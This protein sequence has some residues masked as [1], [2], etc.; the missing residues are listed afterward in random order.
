SAR[1]SRGHSS[2]RPWPAAALHRRSDPTEATPPLVLAVASPTAQDRAELAALHRELIAAG[3]RGVAVIVATSDSPPVAA[4]RLTVTEDAAVTVDIPGLRLTTGAA[5]VPV[6]MLEP[7]AQVFRAAH[8]TTP[9]TGPAAE[10]DTVPG[11]VDPAVGVLT[12]FDPAAMTPEVTADTAPPVAASPSAAVTA[13]EADPTL[14][15]DLAAWQAGDPTR[16]R[17]AILGPIRAH[18]PGQI[19]DS[20]HRLY[21]EMLLYLITR[22]GRSSDRAQIENALWYGHPAG[23]GTIRAAMARLRRWL[24]TRPDGG[25]WISEGNL[26]EGTFTVA[27]GILMDWQLMLRLRERGDRRGEAGI[28]DYRAALQLVHGA[29]MQDRPDQGRYRRHYTWIDGSEISPIRML[30]VV[31]DVAHRLASHSLSVGDPGT[32]RW[33]VGQAWLA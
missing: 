10:P 8:L 16:P 25:E 22:P 17:L 29:P 14:D 20:K 3:Q 4:A 15:E 12:L 30:G 27:D 19:S 28:G 24:G 11:L 18:F 6:D 9:A 5:S 26:P 23:E 21:T 13:V 1:T 31:T 32:V 2:P 33:S 7:M